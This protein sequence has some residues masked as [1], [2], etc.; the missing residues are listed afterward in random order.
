MRSGCRTRRARNDRRL[1]HVVHHHHYHVYR[2]SGIKLQ[3]A[4]YYTGHDS[5]VARAG[6]I[7]NILS[8]VSFRSP[9]L[10]L[11]VTPSTPTAVARPFIFMSTTAQPVSGLAWQLV[12]RVSRTTVYVGSRRF[13]HQW[14][15]C[16]HPLSIWST[17]LYAAPLSVTSSCPE[18]S[19]CQPLPLSPFALQFHRLESNRGRHRRSAAIIIATPRAVTTTIAIRRLRRR[20][21]TAVFAVT[22]RAASLITTPLGRYS[23]RHRRHR[24]NGRGRRHRHCLH[25]CACC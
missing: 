15:V 13:H 12:K 14:C 17:M 23:H 5:S 9:C 10:Q 20:E 6:F 21:S 19:S 3:I 22:V 1:N 8:F 7:F 11:L 4:F 16:H 2:A 24:R 18:H 25:Y